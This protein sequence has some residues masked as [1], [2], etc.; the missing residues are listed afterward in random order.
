[1]DTF[2]A[3]SIVEGFSGEEHSEDEH[4]AAWQH[5]IDTGDC[6]RL[7]GWYGRRAMD[8]VREGYCTL[9]EGK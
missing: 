6:W 7:Q 4:I 2:T 9:P 3:C 8:M 5:L 1:M